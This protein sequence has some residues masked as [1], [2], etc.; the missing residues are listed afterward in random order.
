MSLGVQDRH[1]NLFLRLERKIDGVRD[2]MRHEFARRP[3]A[4]HSSLP[5]D[6][7]RVPYIVHPHSS[8]LD[9]VDP[10]GGSRGDKPLPCIERRG[11]KSL[12]PGLLYSRKP[13]N[14][15]TCAEIARKVLF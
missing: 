1:H 11:P 10:L 4:A 14:T 2:E 12:I 8:S 3:P 15:R 7:A 13:R 9:E 5:Q 6:V